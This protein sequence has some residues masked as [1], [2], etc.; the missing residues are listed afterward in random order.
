MI[1]LQQQNEFNTKF[2][3]YFKNLLSLHNVNTNELLDNFKA[4]EQNN[5][6][7]VDEVS[8]IILRSMLDVPYYKNLTEVNVLVKFRVLQQTLEL[9]QSDEIDETIFSKLEKL[10]N[11]F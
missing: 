3:S 5:I 4:F 2:I 10:R 6:V 11:S 8:M 1:T 7:D 9:I